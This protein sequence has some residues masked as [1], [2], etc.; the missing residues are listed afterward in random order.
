MALD[1]IVEGE[2][3]PVVHQLGT[4]ADAPQRRSSQHVPCA[5]AAVLDDPIA[6][7]DVVQQEVA[8]WTDVLIAESRRDNERAQV[9]R[10]ARSDS[11]ERDRVTDRALY[12]HKQSLA[13]SG[14]GA[15]G[16]AARRPGLSHELGEGLHVIAVV[17]RIGD[18]VEGGD[19]TT[20]GVVLTPSVGS[21]AS[22]GVIKDIG[23]PHL[24]EVGVA[25]E[26]EQAGV[27]VLPPEAGGAKGSV[28]LD[29]RNLDESPY[30]AGRLAKPYVID[31]VVGDGLYEAVADGIEG[32]AESRDVLE[33]GDVQALLDSGRDRPKLNQRLVLIT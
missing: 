30:E 27:L 8:E 9:D 7:S 12:L 29:H 33:R 26:G 5:C 11:V 1:R 24:V 2:R 22:A 10:R 17:F 3:Q 21:Q 28:G 13:A 4:R 16:T 18:V 20:Q 25:G 32:H 19:R 14:G 23:D 6:R 15:D 31:R